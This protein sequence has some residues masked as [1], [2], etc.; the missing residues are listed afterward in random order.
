V[1]S[2]AE[3]ISAFRELF[4]LP[5]FDWVSDALLGIY[6]DQALHIFSKCNYAMLYL[7]A[8]LLAIDNENNIAEGDSGAGMDGGNGENMQEKVGEIQVMM[9]TM[10]DSGLDTYYTSTSY[11][12]RYLAFKK[13]CP[14]YAVS[15]RVAGYGC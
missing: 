15:A 9:K 3:F 1:L 5:Q 2:L 11:G 8:H 10:A 13:A 6:Y 14:S 4:P 7:V 12:R